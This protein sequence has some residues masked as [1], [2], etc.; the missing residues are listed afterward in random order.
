MIKLWHDKAWEEYLYW[1]GQGKKTL[2][3]V[4]TLLKDIDRNALINALTCQTQP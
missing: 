1:Q 3:R 2:K 4:N